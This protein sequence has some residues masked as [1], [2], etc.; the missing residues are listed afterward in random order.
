MPPGVFGYDPDFR[1]PYKTHDIG[2]AKEL[3][4]KAGYPGGVDSRTGARLELTYD[5]GSDST[6]AREAATFDMRCLEQ[7]GIKMRLQVNTFSQYLER[8]MKGT[9]QMTA[10][11]WLAD[12]PDPEFPPA[13]VRPNKPPNPNSASFSNPE[14]DEAVRTD[15]D[16]G[17]HAGK[18]ALIHRMSGDRRGELH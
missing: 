10:G 15:K 9:F 6:R 14:Y 16:D 13:S 17:R 8:T 5:I 11:G 2:K 1:N 18:A 3:L 4:A 12:Y 7:L